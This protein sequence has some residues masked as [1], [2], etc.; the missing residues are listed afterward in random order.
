MTPH[1]RGLPGYEMTGV[2]EDTRIRSQI[3]KPYMNGIRSVYTRTVYDAAYGV[4]N[5][6]VY[7]WYK[8]KRLSV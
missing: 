2:N 4:V 8:K 3:W 5:G 6:A 7:R 1:A